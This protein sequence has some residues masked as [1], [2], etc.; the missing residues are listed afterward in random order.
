MPNVIEVSDRNVWFRLEY[1]ADLVCHS[2]C[3]LVANMF[4]T[5]LAFPFAWRA[6]LVDGGSIQSQPIW[7]VSPIIDFN[8]LGQSCN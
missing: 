1:V 7:I 6:V 2:Q 3:W 4:Y 8:R 5:I